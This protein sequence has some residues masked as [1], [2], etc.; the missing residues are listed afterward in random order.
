MDQE[1]HKELGTACKLAQLYKE[2]KADRC[3]KVAE[4]VGKKAARRFCTDEGVPCRL[5]S[6]T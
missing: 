2:A 3:S 1:F 6:R 4:L 5:L